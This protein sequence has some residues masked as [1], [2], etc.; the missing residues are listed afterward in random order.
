MVRE[1]GSVGGHS[2]SAQGKRVNVCP[3]RADLQQPGCPGYIYQ[4][5]IEDGT[6]PGKGLILSSRC[7]RL[8]SCKK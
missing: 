5:R 1:S 4:G 6:P 7:Q 3:W 2:Q 8:A